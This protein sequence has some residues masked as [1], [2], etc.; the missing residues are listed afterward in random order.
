MGQSGQH[1]GIIGEQEEHTFRVILHIFHKVIDVYREQHWGKNA[2]LGH[3][4]LNAMPLGGTSALSDRKLP[5]SQKTA[6]PTPAVARD[7]ELGG[8][9]VE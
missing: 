7:F 4:S 3:P 6:Y 2:A 1:S 8:Q 9:L 5:P